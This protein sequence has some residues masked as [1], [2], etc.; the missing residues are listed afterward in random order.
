[1]GSEG[2]TMREATA[3]MVAARCHRETLEGV[4]SAMVRNGEKGLPGARALAREIETLTGAAEKL[5]KMIERER[6]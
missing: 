5:Q 2:I 1:M 3:L 6:E 4:Y